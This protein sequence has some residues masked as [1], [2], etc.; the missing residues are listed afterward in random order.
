MHSSMTALSTPRKGRGL[1]PILLVFFLLLPR[2]LWAQE[3]PTRP[4]QLHPQKSRG[5]HVPRDNRQAG[6]EY[7]GVDAP[8]FHPLG[9][10]FC[11]AIAFAMHF[12]SSQLW[13]QNNTFKLAS[14]ASGLMLPLPSCWLSE[15]NSQ[16]NYFHLNFGLK[17]AFHENSKAVRDTMGSV[18]EG[19]EPPH[20][21]FW[22]F[23]YKSGRASEN[24]EQSG[25]E[26]RWHFTLLYMVMVLHKNEKEMKVK[27]LSKG[28]I[29]I[30]FKYKDLD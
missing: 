18:H 2:P 14:T 5:V 17:F 21:A 3:E 1:P 4:V 13:S 27:W 8:A 16:I 22:T 6:S 26:I 23:S 15:I 9:V 30:V 19:S 29:K 20:S 7:H 24:F 12:R 11:K 25:H 28:H 10:Q